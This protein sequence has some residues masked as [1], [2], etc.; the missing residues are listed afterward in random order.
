MSRCGSESFIHKSILNLAEFMESSMSRYGSELSI[1][2]II[3]K[4]SA[5]VVSFT[6]MQENCGL[7]FELGLSD[8]KSGVLTITPWNRFL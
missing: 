2:Q 6:Q 1:H 7:R 4:F 8:S 5:K 3:L